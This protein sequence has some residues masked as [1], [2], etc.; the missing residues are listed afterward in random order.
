MFAQMAAVASTANVTPQLP[1]VNG[2]ISFRDD[3]TISS[4]KL[5]LSG[6]VAY[7]QGDDMKTDMLRIPKVAEEPIEV[8]KKK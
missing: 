1:L 5:T 8:R 2:K 3:R 4:S 7:V 6:F